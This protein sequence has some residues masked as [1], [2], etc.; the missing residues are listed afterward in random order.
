MARI[1][2]VPPV[3]LLLSLL[4]M[5]LHRLLPVTAV[6]RPPL[7]Y[8]G[9]ALMGL[10]LAVAVAAAIRPAPTGASHRVGVAPDIDVGF[11]V[12]ARTPAP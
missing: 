4:A 10:G 9:A 11:S 5:A 6:L 7:S 1:R 3:Y 12:D 2:L 8:A